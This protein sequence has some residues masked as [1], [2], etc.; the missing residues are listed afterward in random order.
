IESV[1]VLLTGRKR[2]WPTHG[3][4]CTSSPDEPFSGV[5]FRIEPVYQ[6]TVAELEARGSF[7]SIF[8]PLAADADKGKLAQVVERLRAT[9]SPQGFEELAVAMAVLAGA[10]QR[11]R[12]FRDV[13]RSLLP[14]EL[15]MQNWI[16]KEG[17]EKGR[18][19]GRKE[20]CKEGR[21][22]SFAHLFERR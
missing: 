12:G 2:A 5:H 4:Y 6:R 10:D 13:V 9:T 15:V 14:R 19:E 20:G 8:A 11:K 17:R 21:L 1:A 18:K 7:W 16:F 22:E 3:E